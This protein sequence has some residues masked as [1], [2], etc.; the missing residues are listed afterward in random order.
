MPIH[1]T[2]DVGDVGAPLVVRVEQVQYCGDG[3]KLQVILAEFVVGFRK[4]RWGRLDGYRRK[5]DVERKKDYEVRREAKE[6]ELCGGGE[7]R[8]G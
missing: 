5:V 3:T 8:E 6:G 2:T 1:Q 7:G 4:F